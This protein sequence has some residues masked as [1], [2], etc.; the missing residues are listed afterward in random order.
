MIKR[1]EVKRSRF[2]EFGPVNRDPGA[3]V[4]AVYGGVDRG[5]ASEALDTERPSER[6]KELKSLRENFAGVRDSF[7]TR[8][9]DFHRAEWKDDPSA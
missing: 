5:S 2:I 1:G 6:R 8:F 3:N 7:E 9:R 4:N